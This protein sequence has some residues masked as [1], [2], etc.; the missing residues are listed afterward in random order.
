MFYTSMWP[1]PRK[2]LE[3][4]IKDYK[5]KYKEKFIPAFGVIATGISGGEPIL[6][7]EKLK[8]DLEIAMNNNVKEVII[9]RLGGLNRKYLKVFNKFIS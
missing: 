5:E 2:F 6:S 8:N 7:P 4:K 9:F 1:F 3:E